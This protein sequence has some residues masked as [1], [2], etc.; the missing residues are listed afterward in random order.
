MKRRI[1]I[2]ELH[3]VEASSVVPLAQKTS[4]IVQAIIKVKV[5]DYVPLRVRLRASISPGIFTGE[6]KYSD[7]ESLEQDPKVESISINKALKSTE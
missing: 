3:K 7:L 2:D 1:Q 6:F 5:A 4:E